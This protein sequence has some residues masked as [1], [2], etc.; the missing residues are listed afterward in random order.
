ME[1]SIKGVQKKL[2]TIILTL[3]MKRKHASSMRIS[4][5]C[6][7]TEVELNRNS[8]CHQGQCRKN[9]AVDLIQIM[10]PL[11]QQKIPQTLQDHQHHQKERQSRKLQKGK[12]DRGQ[13]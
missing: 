1:K 9:V 4:M 6:M 12:Q 8:L 5:R 10:N 11:S 3:G 7:V 2:L 13:I